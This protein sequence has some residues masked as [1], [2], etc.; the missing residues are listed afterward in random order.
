VA[1]LITRK[2]EAHHSVISIGLL[3]WGNLLFARLLKESVDRFGMIACKT[4]FGFWKQNDSPTKNGLSFQCQLLFFTFHKQVLICAPYSELE[5]YCVIIEDSDRDWVK[6]DT[7]PPTR[8]G[9]C[10]LTN[11]SLLCNTHGI[12][13]LFMLTAWD[14][15]RHQSP[16][17]HCACLIPTTFVLDISVAFEQRTRFYFLGSTQFYQTLTTQQ[18]AL[19]PPCKPEVTNHFESESYFLVQIHTEGY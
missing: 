10:W 7:T 18:R 14:N 2:W 16:S 13:Y 19:Q 3:K 9:R 15:K 17:L 12:L 5:V 11:S 1:K 6:A 8:P 4:G